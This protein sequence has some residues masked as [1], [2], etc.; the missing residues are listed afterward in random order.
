M[1]GNPFSSAIIWGDANWSLTGVSVVAK[2]WNETA[3]NY[4]DIPAGG[5]IPSTNGFFI[6][7]IS[8]I[9]SLTI[10]AADRT[11]NITNNYKRAA[12]TS[13]KEILKFKINND[14]NAYYDVNTLGFK[15][16]ATEGWDIAFDSHK[17][18]SFIK[19]T[20]QL[21]T[22]S[23]GQQFSTNYLPE[24]TTTYDVPLDF[25]AGVNTIYHLSVTGVNSFENTS[26]VLE[27]LQTGQEIDLS[28]Q[29]S[30]D[31]SA[32]TDDDDSRFVLHI[33]GVTAVSL[34]SETGG[35]QVFSYAKTVYLQAPGQ[36]SLNGKV[37]IFNMR[38]RQ[39]YSGSLNGMKSQKISLNRKTGIYFVR[40]EDGNKLVTR[41]VFIK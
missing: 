5:I 18:F 15:A 17:L 38:G 8:G 2:V 19:T 36:K 40:V 6:Q 23:K 39:V 7:V 20:P 33:N 12:E 21:W 3:A 4:S 11:H 37:S 34:L 31:F 14:A 13:R 29:S 9:N 25:R 30:Y 27:D 32:T 16:N 41:K 35:V 26:L 1:L 22:V 10:P 28:Q 24:V